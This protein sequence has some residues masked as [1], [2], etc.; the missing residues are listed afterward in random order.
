MLGKLFLAAFA[1]TTRA[2]P[3]PFDLADATADGATI[4]SPRAGVLNIQPTGNTAIVR[5]K[6]REGSWNLDSAAAVLFNIS[7]QGAVVAT[8][9]GLIWSDLAVS[10]GAGSVVSARVPVMRKELQVGLAD[11]FPAMLG[12]P[13]GSMEIWTGHAG[14]DAI[15]EL[16]LQLGGGGLGKAGFVEISGLRSLDWDRPLGPASSPLSDDIYPFVDG[17]G[18]SSLD[19]WP[20]KVL[21]SGD[22]ALRKAEED[23]DLSANPG[24]MMWSRFG[25]DARSG[26]QQLTGTG[27]FRTEK[28]AGRWWLVD[29]DGYLFWSHGITGVGSPV[30]TDVSGDRAK[31]FASL[32]SGSGKSVDFAAN[33]EKL[34]Y[35]DNHV[36]TTAALAHKRLRSWHMNTIGNWANEAV[37]L[38][39]EVRTPYVVPVSYWWKG[40]SSNPTVFV[41]DPNF[42][43]AVRKKLEDWAAKGIGSDPYFL[44]A[45]VDNELH[46]WNE[47]QTVAEIYFSTIREEMNRALPSKLY[48]GCR[49]DFHFWPEQGPKTPVRIAAKYAD[50][51]SFN[52]YRYTAEQLSPPSGVDV[53]IIIGEFHFGA[54]DRGLFHTGLRSVADQSQRGAVYELFMSS[55]LSNPYLVGAHWFQWR[56]M[57]VT[58]RN[59][60]MN[61]QIGFLDTVDTPHY[62]TITA[63]RA[64]GASLYDTAFT[65]A[66]V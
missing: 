10:L 53:P 50:V 19:N 60:G 25:G 44:G 12:A 45:F 2:V 13:G 39:T 40:K 61:Y 29:P 54:L 43:P 6:A 17:Y 1:S 27:H 26:A 63:A 36:N 52:H 35:G 49:F 41:N 34:K 7:G 23:E 9:D 47:N 64:I 21:N 57:A 18:Q 59:G 24:P 55:A 20:R 5:V 14:T 42:R 38:Q 11:R 4:S 56:D 8:L 22:L 16:T 58:G 66:W 32:P 31:F 3:L 15:K 65:A 33:N 37:T 28:V 48:L 51:V 30:E 62:E 46:G